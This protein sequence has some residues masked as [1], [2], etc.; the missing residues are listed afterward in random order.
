MDAMPCDSVAPLELLVTLPCVLSVVTVPF[1][2]LSVGV[3][4]DVLRQVPPEIGLRRNLG[5]EQGSAVSS[6]PDCLRTRDRILIRTRVPDMHGTLSGPNELHAE[7]NGL[8]R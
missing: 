2:E 4:I 3:P 8:A 7:N 1:M 5:S 6:S